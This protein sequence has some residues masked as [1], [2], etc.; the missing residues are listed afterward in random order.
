VSATERREGGERW[1]DGNSAERDRSGA[2]RRVAAR[3]RELGAGR[4]DGAD[5]LGR[6]HARQAGS[7]DERVR[8][9]DDRLDEESP[10]PYGLGF[11]INVPLI[12][13]LPEASDASAKSTF[14]KLGAK[15]QTYVRVL[16]G[17]RKRVPVRGIVTP[18][19]CPHGGWP[20]ATQFNFEDGSSV[21]STS[22]IACPR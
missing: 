5:N 16:A 22:K 15:G 2:V 9:R 11:S 8:Q 21:T 18:R 10:K 4:R 14:L 19:S 20:V 3:R 1:S 12:K 13:V 17:K 6:L 7:A